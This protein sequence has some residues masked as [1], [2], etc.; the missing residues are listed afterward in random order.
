VGD[1]SLAPIGWTYNGL[2]P[3]LQRQAPGAERDATGDRYIAFMRY[4]LDA[5]AEA[6]SGSLLGAARLPPFRGRRALTQLLLDR[7]ARLNSYDAAT[8]LA[9]VAKNLNEDWLD[10]VP[11]GA[12]PV[13]AKNAV[14]VSFLLD[15]RVGVADRMVAEGANIHTA[16]PYPFGQGLA[17]LIAMLPALDDRAR[18][19]RVIA[20]YQRHGG[21]FDLPLLRDGTT[22]LM[23]SLQDPPL[24]R[25]LLE[26]GAK[27][28][29]RDAAGR[30]ALIVALDHAY[31]VPGEPG[32]PYAKVE[33]TRKRPEARLVNARALLEHGAD[34]NAFQ[35][36]NTPLM[37]AYPFERELVALLFERGGTI[38]PGADGL[39]QAFTAGRA[40]IGPLSWS[41]LKGHAELPM[42][43]LRREG[44]SPQADCGAAYYAALFD[45]VDVLQSIA[46]EPSLAQLRDERGDDLLWAAARTDAAGA[47]AWLLDRGSGSA[48]AKRPGG[49]TLLMQA[50]DHGAVQVIRV[51]LARG[52]DA[53]A[54]DLRGRTAA[55][56]AIEARQFEA[57]AILGQA[58]PA[59]R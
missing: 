45:R 58:A 23:R 33:D 46:A 30:T 11:F 27:A 50:A 54:R 47:V 42:R 17:P 12:G 15:G 5:G 24:A 2:I 52:A 53:A 31:V 32:N 8:G 59:S 9:E 38:R 26:A 7:G 35:G 28:D 20:F 57:A 56:H 22:T 34:V 25:M 40:F 14:M 43:W 6:T 4:L 10:L 13:Q 18:Q 29:V 55:D 44:H 49:A 37:L 41:I 51:L 16:H 21:D 48:S 39:T 1:P 19:R 3:A 36:G